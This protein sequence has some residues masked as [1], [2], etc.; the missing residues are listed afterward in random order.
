MNVVTQGDRPAAHRIGA[1]TPMRNPSNATR[2]Q[3][4]YLIVA[5]LVST[6]AGFL[7][8]YDNL[9]ISGAI[10]YLSRFY[11]L[12]AAGVGWVA[13]CAVI[14]CLA[15]SLTAGW[16][17]DRLG[18]KSA[19][20]SARSASPCLRSAYGSLPTRWPSIRCGASWAAWGSAARRS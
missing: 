8:G 9:V 20:G 15:G 19:F 10:G 16:I 3:S 5:T 18:A 11:A 7:F 6:L 13:S 1:K 2:R 17:V 12:D 4:F 14:G